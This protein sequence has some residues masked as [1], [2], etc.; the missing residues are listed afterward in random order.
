MES[1]N[2]IA[3]WWGALIATTVLLLDY[4]KWSRS[5]PIIRCDAKYGW[6]IMAEGVEDDNEYIFYTVTNV[7]DRPTTITKQGVLCWPNVFKRVFS[8]ADAE[9][10]IKGGIHGMGKVPMI[11]KPGEVWNGCGTI[12]DEI[13]DLVKKGDN[14]FLSLEFSHRQKSYLFKLKIGK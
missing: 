3:A 5:G 9:F 8:D 14:L 2:V 12:N 1:W 11:I 10:W 13:R 6:K 4:Y 7:G